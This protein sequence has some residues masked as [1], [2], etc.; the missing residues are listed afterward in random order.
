MGREMVKTG[1]GGVSLRLYNKN[2]LTLSCLQ[3]NY[4]ATG[5]SWLDKIKRTHYEI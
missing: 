3:R 4:K 5:S 1:V 2:I